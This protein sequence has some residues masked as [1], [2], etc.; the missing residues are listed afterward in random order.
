MSVYSSS[1]Y[2]GINFHSAAESWNV[3]YEEEFIKN[4]KGIQLFTCRWM[5]VDIEPKA[6]VFLNHGYAMECSVSM[7]G[8]A[9]RQVKAGFG[10]YGIDNQ[11]HGKSD[12]IQGFIASFDDMVDDCFQH[13]TSICERKEN[14]NKLRILLGESMGGATVLRLH[15]KKPE[16]WDGGVL[17][18]PMCKIAEDMKPPQLVFNVLL[19][20]TRFIPTWR[21]VPG[22]DII[23]LAFKDPKIREEIRNKELFNV[24][25]DLEK[26]LKE[27][28]MPFLVVHGEDDKVTDPFT[29]K[30]L[31]ETSSSTDKT[32]KLYPKMWHALT[33]GEFTENTDIV[34]AD[35]ISW[36]NERIAQGNSRLESEKKNVNDE[37]RKK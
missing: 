29:S 2:V 34:F 17:V 20:L 31:Y 16:F 37:L 6:L 33:Y 7:K 19:Q 14:K 12:G 11:G 27:V 1:I 21:I 25:V 5:P 15:R 35:I 36:I 8:V 22:Q 9:M 3:I 23:D 32:L 10:V 28:T 26:K 13:F 30:L 18:A 4:S 24:T